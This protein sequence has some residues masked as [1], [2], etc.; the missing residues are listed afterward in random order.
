M[1]ALL[2]RGLRNRI[3]KQSTIT[4]LLSLLEITSR[5]APPQESQPE[6]HPNV[7]YALALCPLLASSDPIIAQQI[8]ALL[9]VST[10]GADLS[11][12]LKRLG[13]ASGL[14]GLLLVSLT[15]AM[16]TQSDTESERILLYGILA[17]VALSTADLVEIM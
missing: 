2:I 17:E 7:G 15:T 12:V 3:T 6:V 4:L 13:G 10:Q 1:A 16:L 5:H 8:F 14:D 11:L 9:G